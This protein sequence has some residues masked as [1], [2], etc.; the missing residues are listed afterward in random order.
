MRFLSYE[1]K[2]EIGSERRE[3]VRFLS[4]TFFPLILPSHSQPPYS[5]CS[6]PHGRLVLLSS[7]S[8]L[9]RLVDGFLISGRL[10][11]RLRPPRPL[12]SPSI[13]SQSLCYVQPR[14]HRISLRNTE[15]QLLPRR[16]PGCVVFTL[17]SPSP[18]RL[19]GSRLLTSTQERLPLRTSP[20]S[21]TSNRCHPFLEQ[22]ER[23]RMGERVS[24]LH[25][26]AEVR[27]GE[28]EDEEAGLFE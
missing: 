19:F 7:R 12:H 9:R 13:R 23:S 22:L 16:L 25:G 1:A 27:E 15:L 10:C 26:E 11:L 18:S 20:S 6:R 3:G 8:L 2:R 28:E 4:T 21:S 24:V 17:G 14:T 5:F